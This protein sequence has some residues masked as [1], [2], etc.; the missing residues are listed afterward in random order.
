MAA[1][2]L[3]LSDAINVHQAALTTKR[4]A[5]PS[6]A[7]AGFLMFIHHSYFHITVART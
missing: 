3:G 6:S 2:A 4:V 7:W 1:E 5:R